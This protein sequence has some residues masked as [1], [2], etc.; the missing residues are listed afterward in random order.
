MQDSTRHIKVWTF[1]NYQTEID[2]T[3][4]VAKGKVLFMYV[5]V[6]KFIHTLTRYY[7]L[8]FRED[9]FQSSGEFQNMIMI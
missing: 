7:L 8:G 4:N 1:Q 5:C 3:F 2:V 6:Y 9:N